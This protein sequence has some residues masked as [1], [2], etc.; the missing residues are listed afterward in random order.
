MD[1][2]RLHACRSPNSI[3]ENKSNDDG[4]ICQGFLE[5]I[6]DCQK[7]SVED[8][9]LGENQSSSIPVIVAS[10]PRMTVFTAGSLSISLFLWLLVLV[11]GSLFVVRSL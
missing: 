10:R 5:K 8:V 4:A 1:I 9:F 11:R 3:D 7:R 2:L 6:W